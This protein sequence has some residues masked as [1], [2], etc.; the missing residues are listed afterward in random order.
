MPP[1][2]TPTSAK[3]RRD[4]TREID[5]ANGGEKGRKIRREVDREEDKED[6]EGMGGRRRKKVKWRERKRGN[7]DQKKMI[8]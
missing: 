6:E 7:L 3:N 1:P 8:N 4:A 2:S 5:L